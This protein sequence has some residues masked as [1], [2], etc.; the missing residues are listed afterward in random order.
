[1]DT[2]NVEPIHNLDLYRLEGFTG[3]R[4][5]L[6]QLHEWM[7]GGDDLPAIAISG[8]QGV[9]KSALA[10]AAAWSE[11]H[12]FPDGILRVSPAGASPFRL[13]DVVRALDVG[14]GTTLTRASTERWGVAI[15][16]Q[17]YRRR[18]LIILDKLAGATEGEIH[19][20]VEI[21]GHLHESGGN[22]R[23]L[24]ID[25][26]FQPAI[27]TLVQNQHIRLG[28][29]NRA[30]AET[31]LRRRAPA[32]VLEK[33]LAHAD[34]LFAIT[35]GSPLCL[36]LALGLLLD[37]E[38]RELAQI[39]R[40]FGSAADDTD[41]AEPSQSEPANQSGAGEGVAREGVVREGFAGSGSTAAAYR[42]DVHRVAALAIETLAIL[43]P[44]V[45]PFLDRLVTARGGAS[46]AAL[47]ELIWPDL[48]AG[49]SLQ[50]T[51]DALAQRGIIERDSYRGRVVLHPVIRR[52]LEQNA[53][54][55][56]EEWERRHAHFH[57]GTVGRYLSLPLERWPEVDIEW[58]N[59]YKAADWCQQRVERI[60]QRRVLEMAS[61]PALDQQPLALPAEVE[62]DRIEI[63]A[64]LRLVR[65]YGLAL[66]HYAFWRHPPGII[67][68]LSA[69]AVATATLADPRDYGWFL[70]SIGRH[71]FVMGEVERAIEW[72][73]RARAIFDPRDLIQELAYVLTDLGTSY[74]LL[75]QPRVALDYLHAAI[76]CVA[77]LG[78]QQGLA[79][80]WMNLG[81]A[82]YSMNNPE[83]ALREHR[84]A[85][86]I[87][88][89]HNDHEV[90]GSAFNNMGLAAEAMERLDDAVGAYRAALF[91]FD[92]A[93]DLT[94]V[95]ATYN[96]LGSASY[97]R[98]D[99]AQALEWYERDLALLEARGAWTDMAATLH[100]LGHVALEMGETERALAYFGQSR[101]LYAAF[102]LKE[103]VAEEEEMIASLTRPPVEERAERKG[104]FQR[105][106]GG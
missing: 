31:F 13:Y 58:G 48:G 11:L 50:G 67:A 1:M 104:F 82:Y 61:D 77:Q 6:L 39:L 60:W 4:G 79:T 45:G 57:A 34:E 26:N 95:S 41:G 28:G 7:T 16:E 44:E 55:L 87:G 10:T 56:G 5:E 69:G 71:F 3:R 75:D 51:L 32:P 93:G 53:A 100:N 54:L 43:E 35:G 66:A 78:D 85:L 52:Y 12:A 17:L 24:L 89:R 101:D 30:D 8:E 91:A 90:I 62:K 88:V 23:L 76:D 96:N 68:W 18:R 92:K 40:Q 99:Y 15:L 25:R 42:P 2:G 37:Y 102:E 47:E 81:S 33:A 94:G 84:K 46:Y 74:R 80:A 9:G 27:A 49:G 97:A 36:R 86:R 105:L 83:R 64:D 70:M 106:R 20:L 98:H 103:Y 22:S 65:D 14:I 59:V 38:W 72:F 19:T 29:L 73:E 21:I 63:M